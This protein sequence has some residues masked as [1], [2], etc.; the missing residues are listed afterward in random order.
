[1]NGDL[2]GYTLCDK[3]NLGSLHF[4]LGME[5]ITTPDGLI[6]SQQRY[7]LN[8]LRKSNMSGAKP[9]KSP[10]STAHTLSLL[11]GDPLINP[12]SCKSLVDALAISLSYLSWH[13]I[14][15][16]QSIPIYAS[17]H[18]SPPLG[19]K[20]HT[21]LS[22]VHHYLQ[23]TPSPVTLH[24]SSFLKRWLGRMPQW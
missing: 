15:G 7:I 14:R 22:Q 3:K 16:E 6:L 9:V 19:C 11:F 23:P 5:A 21:P 12:S 1:M 8:L 2:L 10:M 4:F 13:L 17:A 18:L 24:P 20:T